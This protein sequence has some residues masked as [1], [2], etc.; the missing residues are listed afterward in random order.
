MN[1]SEVFI[2]SFI[3][4]EVVLWFEVLNSLNLLMMTRNMNEKLFPLKSKWPQMTKDT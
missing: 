2:A 4:R 3:I 1:C